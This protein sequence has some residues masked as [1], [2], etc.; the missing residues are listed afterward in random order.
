MR[1][2]GLW[3]GRI[4]GWARGDG[5]D[6]RG[7]FATERASGQAVRCHENSVIPAKHNNEIHAKKQR[8]NGPDGT[9]WLSQV[10]SHFDADE[11]P[12]KKAAT[13][14][15]EF[16][17]PHDRSVPARPYA[18]LERYGGGKRKGAWRPF[19]YYRKAA[20]RWLMNLDNQFR[21]STRKGARFEMSFSLAKS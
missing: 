6:F 10:E 8:R 17:V 4:E 7:G 21:R 1:P 3:F 14:K 5:P 20:K 11:P 2:E 12:C 16:R 18:W 15:G 9:R 13:G 19:T